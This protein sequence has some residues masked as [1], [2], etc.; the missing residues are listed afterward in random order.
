MQ[1]DDEDEDNDLFSDCSSSS[2]GGGGSVAGA[3]DVD[4]SP[5]K[6]QLPSS[7]RSGAK[8]QSMPVR[9]RKKNMHALIQDDELAAIDALY[10]P[11]RAHPLVA[12]AAA[13]N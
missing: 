6:S 7:Q 10:S 2:D 11:P 13:V 12:S 8:G 9:G 4:S 3:F 5:V 1:D